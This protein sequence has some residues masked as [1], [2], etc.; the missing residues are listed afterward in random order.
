MIIAV[1]RSITK[2]IYDLPVAFQYAVCCGRAQSIK[3]KYQVYLLPK[4]IDEILIVRH[5]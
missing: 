4:I 1:A 5:L 3:L 2:S